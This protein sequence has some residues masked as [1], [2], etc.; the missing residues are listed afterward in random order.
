MIGP[1]GVRSPMAAGD[2]DAQFDA[3]YTACF[4]RVRKALGALTHDT[5]A[6]E[7]A[8]QEAF[9]RA[10][11]HWPKLMAYDKP[12]AW[13]QRVAFQR[14]R[15]IQRS[16]RDQP[17]DE[18]TVEHPDPGADLADEVAQREELYAAIRTLPRRRA[19]VIVLCHLR[20]YSRCEVATMLRITE[21]TVRTHLALAEAQLH[22]L[23]GLPD[24]GHQ[25]ET[26]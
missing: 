14:L 2:P 21:S 5:H 3:F 9:V 12:E 4:S 7:D 16:R 22:R 24:T 17:T 6:A 13:V 23:L 11:R 26:G 20:G 18:S 10:K 1:S 19:E 25:G 15:R 8:T